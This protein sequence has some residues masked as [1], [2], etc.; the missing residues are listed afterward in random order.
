ME[1]SKTSFNNFNNVDEYLST[2][3]NDSQ[4]HTLGQVRAIIKKTAPEAEEVISYQMPA[5]RYQ[6]ILVYFAA[7]KNHWGL[8]PAS[9]AIKEAFKEELSGYKQT[10]GA[11]QFPWDEPFPETLLTRLVEW[12]MAENLRGSRTKSEK[13]NR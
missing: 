3:T 1:K 11:I 9:S 2:I 10:K 7:W 5:Y 6:G 8:Y 13:N 4:R 12:R